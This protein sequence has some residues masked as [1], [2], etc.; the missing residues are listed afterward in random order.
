MIVRRSDGHV[1]E[2]DNG[3]NNSASL[4]SNT[5]PQWAPTDGVALPR[6]APTA[7]SGR[8]GTCSRPANHS[9]GGLVQGQ[10]SCKQLWVM[11]VDKAKLATGIIDPSSAPFW[12]PGQSINEQYVS[13]QWTTSV[14]S[15]Q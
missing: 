9:C 15:I 8:M 1:F 13:P 11:A 12:I 2:L 4:T 3:S 7:P 10:A 5:W 14:I 6:G